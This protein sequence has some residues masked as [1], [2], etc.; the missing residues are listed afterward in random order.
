MLYSSLALNMSESLEQT[1]RVFKDSS[2]KKKK[3]SFFSPCIS[4]RPKQ[5]NCFCLLIPEGIVVC[6][7]WD[8][9]KDAFSLHVLLGFAITA[10]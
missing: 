10:D 4:N 7:R 8:L 1:A 9:R 2:F 5:S 3:N 6:V